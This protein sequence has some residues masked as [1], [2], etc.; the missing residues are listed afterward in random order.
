[1]TSNVPTVVLLCHDDDRLDREG[2]ARWLASTFRLVGMVIL[3]DTPQRKWRALMR[4]RKRSGWSGLADAL[5]FHVHYALTCARADAAWAADQVAQ[6]TA[7]YPV[8]LDGVARITT[9]NPN[10]DETR[11]FLAALAPDL[12]IARCKHLLKPAIFEIARAG[13]VALHPGVCPEYRNAHGCFWA[14]TRRDLTRVGMTLLRI[15][16]GV[17]TGTVFLQASCDFDER[18]ESHVVIQARAVVNNLD[19]IGRVLQRMADGTATAI[20]TT[21][22][23]S[24]VWGHPRLSAYLKWRRA[25]RAERRASN[26]RRTVVTSTGI[27]HP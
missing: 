23:D 24:A 9:A 22:R 15:D 26:D 11:R 14:M 20:D 16:R 8:A 3:E 2:M 25:L 7:R 10:G 12:V 27:Q 6:L 13:T 19:A 21:G 1:L 4:E 5:A 18:H 17:D